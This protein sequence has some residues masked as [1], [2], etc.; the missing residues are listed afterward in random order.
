MVDSPVVTAAPFRRTF[1][2]LLACGLWA[3]SLSSCELTTKTSDL[4]GGCPAHLPGPALVKVDSPSGPYCIDATEV[5]N[6]HYQAFIAS[7]AKIAMPAGC[8]TVTSF[9]PAVVGWPIGGLQSTP[10]GRVNWCQSFAFCAWAGKRLCGTIGGGAL[11]PMYQTDTAVSQWFNACSRSGTR[12]FPY[13]NTYDPNICAGPATAMGGPVFVGKQRGC[14]GGFPGLFDMSGNVWEWGDTC[15]PPVAGSNN[16]CRARGGAF[17][18]ADT[19]FACKQDR[20]WK[21]TDPATDIG[22]RC[23]RDL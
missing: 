16:F 1:G 14:E 18:S 3:S 12:T 6:A 19:E 10:V 8:E 22:F 20:N 23:C 7:G 4:E 17:D 9:V 2:R 11:A 13:G 21:R 5:T 15:D